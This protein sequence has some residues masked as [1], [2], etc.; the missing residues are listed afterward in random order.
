M[1]TPSQVAVFQA[2]HPFPLTDGYLSLLKES[3]SEWRCLGL[4]AGV[5]PEVMVMTHSRQHDRGKQGLVLRMPKR[6][7]LQN[8]SQSSPNCGERVNSTASWPGLNSAA[9]S[10]A[11]S[12]SQPSRETVQVQSSPA[13]EKPPRIMN[14]L[15]T[16]LLVIFLLGLCLQRIPAAPQGILEDT[17]C[18]TG[19]I[20]GAI[21]FSNLRSFYRTS[22]GC[23]RRAVVFVTLQNREVC[24]NPEAKW[25]QVAIR[26]LRRKQ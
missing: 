26:R 1:K 21:R 12:S 9:L 10:Q 5:F 24:A 3:K 8:C 7:F 25:V 20:E 2:R 22:P 16:A 6:S 18:C 14:S 13:K 15:T 11:V 19:V 23:R 4:T 17:T